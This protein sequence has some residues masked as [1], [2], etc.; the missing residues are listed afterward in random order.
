MKTDF[1]EEAQK[2]KLVDSN[3]LFLAWYILHEFRTKKK[4]SLKYGK[5]FICPNLSVFS[6]CWRI[7][8]STIVSILKRLTSKSCIKHLYIEEER[9]HDETDR[10][11]L[12]DVKHCTPKTAKIPK[13]RKRFFE[14]TAED[15]SNNFIDEAGDLNLSFYMQLDLPKLKAFIEQYLDNWWHNR[16]ISPRGNV[17]TAHVQ[18]EQ[19]IEKLRALL[20]DY[21]TNLLFSWM[22][23]NGLDFMATMLF[24]AS[25]KYF[26]IENVQLIDVKDVPWHHNELYFRIAVTDSFF[27]DFQKNDDTSMFKFDSPKAP[28]VDGQ[29]SNVSAMIFTE[30]ENLEYE[31]KVYYGLNE[32]RK[33]LCRKLF[34]KDVGFSFKTLEVENCVYDDDASNYRQDKFKKLV[35]RVNKTMKSEFGIS[36][37]I[38]YTSATVRRLK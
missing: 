8:E 17:L 23:V 9:F 7:S 32:S 16:L 5:N 36:E 19:V 38:H 31:G 15:S 11:V 10:F 20:K 33:C 12:V 34:T 25:H 6:S 13:S 29:V 24:L 28:H 18:V 21:S 30:D 26:I 2:G 22:D 37:F 1:F 4:R 14:K 27:S 35:E 3:M